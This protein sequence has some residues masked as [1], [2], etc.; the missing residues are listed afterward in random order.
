MSKSKLCPYRRHCLSA[1]TC[2]TCDFEKTFVNLHTK[3]QKQKAKNKLL[4]EENDRLRERIDT[5]TN[6]N[7]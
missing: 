1:G 6:P 5:L 4:Q 2:E 7:L 3:L